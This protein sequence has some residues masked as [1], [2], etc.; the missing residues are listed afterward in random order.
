MEKIYKRWFSD[1]ATEAD[2]STFSDNP[3][4]ALQEYCQRQWRVS[5]VYRLLEATGPGHA[6]KFHVEVSVN[7]R[8]LASA[9]GP[10]KREAESRAALK[11][12]QS[13][14]ASPPPS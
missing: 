9:R 1:L 10:N 12:L 4:G 5:P 14:A 8:V 2:G 7:S 11:A 6:R 3:K 13:L